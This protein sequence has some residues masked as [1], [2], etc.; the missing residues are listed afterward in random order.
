[1][2]TP[3]KWVTSR[4]GGRILP[5]RRRRPLR[6]LKRRGG[7]ESLREQGT[8]NREQGKCRVPQ[9][10]PEHVPEPLRE[11]PSL[12][13]M[14]RQSCGGHDKGLR[15]AKATERTWAAQTNA[16]AAELVRHT[17]T[18]RCPRALLLALAPPRGRGVAHAHC[19][20][21]R[22]ALRTRVSA[23]QARAHCPLACSASSCSAISATAMQP[24]SAA[25][26]R[27]GCSES[28]VRARTLRT[29]VHTACSTV[30]IVLPFTA[31]LPPASSAAAPR[32]AKTKTQRS[33]R[34]ILED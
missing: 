6:I 8:G 23:P 9:V 21:R 12:A 11:N 15:Q 14:T 30:A 24:S 20:R 10:F 4:G 7:G 28:R 33:L 19:A 34:D 31:L 26:W 2:R 29:P 1:V 5:P 18:S 16:D 22:H 3:R 17:A 27:I 25:H 32:V 13:G